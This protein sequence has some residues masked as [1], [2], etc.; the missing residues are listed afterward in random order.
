MT[1]GFGLERRSS[2]RLWRALDALENVDRVLV[3]LASRRSR[4]EAEIGRTAVVD[5]PM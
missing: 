1:L 5:E 2:S 4:L 3:G